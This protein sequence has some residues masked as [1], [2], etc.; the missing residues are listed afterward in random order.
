[1][2]DVT[3][4]DTVKR[5]FAIRGMTC[6][7][8]ARRVERRVGKMEGVEQVQVNLA[9]EQMEVLFDAAILDERAIAAAV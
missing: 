1:M 8:C 2:D 3:A 5:D 4:A 6:A 7:A 9:T